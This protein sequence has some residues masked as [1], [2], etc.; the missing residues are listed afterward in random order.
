MTP[1]YKMYLQIGG[2]SQTKTIANPIYKDDLSVDYELESGEKFYR[3]KL[4]GKLTFVRDEYQFIMNANFEDEI[5]LLIEKSNDYGLTYAPYYTGKFMRTDCTINTDDMTITVQPKTLDQYNDVIAGMEKEYNLIDLAPAIER[6]SID[7]RP[8]IQIYKAGDSIIS[9]FLGGSAWEQDAEETRDKT[10]LS[11][12]FHFS[13]IAS[14]KEI[15][16]SGGGISA[17]NGTYAGSLEARQSAWGRSYKGNL[18]SQN[19]PEY[20]IYYEQNVRVIPGSWTYEIQLRR[21]TDNVTLYRWG[22]NEDKETFELVMNAEGGGATGTKNASLRDI[23]IFARY[24]CD[25]E[26]IND[27]DTYLLPDDDLVIDNRNYKRVI[28]YNINVVSI[29]QRLSETP[30]EWGRADNGKYFLPPLSSFGVKFYPVARSTW[31]NESLWFNFFLAD[32]ILEQEARKEFVLR[33]AYPIASVISVLLAQFAPGI[34]HEETPEYSQF[35]YGTAPGF[36][37]P[38]RLMVT[39]KSN[40]LI[41]E[42][43]TPA[44]KAPTKL[45]DFTEM[46][47]NCFGCY[48]FIENGKFRIEHIV[49]FRN[50]GSYQYAPVIG[51]D[52]TELQNI[53]NGKK[54]AYSTSEY[55]FDKE[56]MPERY[57]Y[58]WMDDVTDIFQGMPIEVQSKYVQAGKIE[59]INI[60]NFT[61]DVDMML[62]NPGAMSQDGFALLA[63]TLQSGEYKLPYRNIYLSNVEY[64]VQ[65]GYLAF[66]YLQPTYLLYD[67]PAYSIKVNGNND[68]ARGIQRNKKQTLTFPTGDDDPNA[69]QLVK[70]NMGNGQIDKLSINLSSRISKTTLKYDTE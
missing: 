50:G 8:I 25:V 30:T 10:R 13:E 6:V 45:K 34:T 9:C 14:I 26:K 38:F 43:Q 5:L 15:E 59:K 18:E 66:P 36:N 65:N 1:K 67:M 46:L 47:R 24:L 4:S 54:W 37:N 52:L 44:Q 55:T 35:L 53:R 64:R 49:W 42:Y 29:S 3:A 20:Y 51:Y 28:G 33:D 57:E 2:D 16:I 56:Q 17:V 32:R 61:S 41:G 48:W 27:L 12:Y 63:A 22:G 21:K 69:L 39:P 11:N 23:G 60:S 31:I 19:N 68:V 7:K 70:T 62:L 40:V 58:E